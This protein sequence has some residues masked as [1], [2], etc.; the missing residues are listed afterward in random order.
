MSTGI[1]KAV[2]TPPKAK[3]NKKVEEKGKFPAAGVRISLGERKLITSPYKKR[4]GGGGC[5]GKEKT[6]QNENIV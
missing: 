4:K 2:Q 6:K 5:S 3:Q 1:E